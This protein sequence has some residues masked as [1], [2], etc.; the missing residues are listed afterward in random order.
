ME[1]R[2]RP[3]QAFKIKLKD[4]VTSFKMEAT[5]EASFKSGNITFR[6][7]EELVMLIDKVDSNGQCFGQDLAGP[8]TD[9]V[10]TKLIRA[11]GAAT[12]YVS[13]EVS[14][15]EGELFLIFSASK[16]A[17]YK[18]T[19]RIKNY[20][21]IQYMHFRELRAE[22]LPNAVSDFYYSSSNNYQ[23][24][25]KAGR[26]FYS[27]VSL[28][29][30]GNEIEADKALRDMKLLINS[31]SLERSYIILNFAAAYRSK[32]C[33]YTNTP[34]GSKRLL[35][36]NITAQSEETKEKLSAETYNSL[37]Q[38]ITAKYNNDA[39]KILFPAFYVH[40]SN[41]SKAYVIYSEVKEGNIKLT[42][43]RTDS[44]SL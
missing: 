10:L 26:L 34:L 12:F 31:N 35:V 41:L 18:V 11:I 23:S 14:N 44:V 40:E 15:K 9:D 7:G 30:D 1:N 21:I 24:I 38:K 28:L 13:Y 3:G 20:N 16:E 2:N 29:R 5:N 6:N 17:K 39:S 27:N 4:M 22:K 33:T 43:D 25:N 8:N 37:V 32:M 42:F 36:T 19:G